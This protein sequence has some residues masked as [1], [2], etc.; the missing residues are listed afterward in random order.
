MQFSRRPRR[1][2]ALYQDTSSDCAYACLAMILDGFGTRV[3]VEVLKS[4]LAPGASGTGLPQLLKLAASF[5][6]SGTAYRTE[7]DTLAAIPLPAILHWDMNHF[8]VLASVRRGRYEILD[9]ARG[10][11]LIS[12]AALSNHFTGIAVRFQCLPGYVRARHIIRASMLDLWQQ[13]TGT[14][15]ALAV[16]LILGIMSQLFMVVSPLIY[17]AMINSNQANLATILPYL[18]G[19]AL[20][21]NLLVV[22]GDVARRKYVVELGASISRQAT[23]N[24]INHLLRLPYT[25]FQQRRLGDVASRVESTRFLRDALTDGALSAILDGVFSIIALMILFLACPWAA[26]IV[27]VSSGL[28]AIFRALVHRQFRVLE[29]HTFHAQAVEQGVSTECLRAH[30]S[31]KAL[32]MEASRASAWAGA[33][34]ESLS[35]TR[36]IQVFAGFMSAGR[37]AFSS[38]ELVAVTGWGVWLVQKGDISLGTLFAVLALRQIVQDRIYPLIEK[39]FDFDILRARMHRLRDITWARKDAEHEIPQEPIQVPFG[40]I[41]VTDLT[42]RYEMTGPLIVDNLQVD[43]RPGEFLAIKGLS[44]AGKSTFIKLLAGLLRPDSGEVHIDGVRLTPAHM[45]SYRASLGIVLQDDTLFSGTVLDNITAFDLDADFLRAE[46]AARFA[47]IHDD[48]A[49]MPMGYFS[50][51]G[52]MGSSLS[53]GQKQRLL[54]AR[55]LYRAPKILLLDE[56]TANLDPAREFAVISNLRALGVT[57]V[58]V[59]HRS[60]TLEM[61]DRVMEFASGRLVAPPAG[62]D[63]PVTAHPHVEADAW[64]GVN[65]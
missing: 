24:V 49:G 48:I 63:N 5:N 20:A 27:A 56:G 17:A 36:D 25:Y 33:N 37:S 32:G 51:I 53:G 22:G 29:A 38:V 14:R 7:P 57:I 2:R 11:L 44:G 50:L 47:E 42:F 39:A 41:R 16:I 13:A 15:H 62:S 26:V 45:E 18:V 19:A 12:Q 34:A 59:A 8:V 58:S 46:K 61:A 43:I 23:S 55:A 9:P 30:V 54:L 31:I 10:R 60:R 4:R 40:E 6:L 52:D 1:I 65:T 35:R 28:Y 21:S 3:S 64:V